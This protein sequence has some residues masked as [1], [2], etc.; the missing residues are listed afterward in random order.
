MATGA[1]AFG[2]STTALVFDAILHKMPLPVARLRPELPLQLGQIIAKAI[3]KSRE[4]RYQTAADLR[5]DLT[6]LKRDTDSSREAAVSDQLPKPPAPARTSRSRMIMAVLALVFLSAAAAVIYRFVIQRPRVR[7]TP[8]KMV[9]TKLTDEARVSRAAL[10]RDG[11]YVAYI[12]R[13]GSQ[14]TLWL[15]QVASQSAVQLLPSLQ[16]VYDW[17]GFSPDGESIYFETER[18]DDLYLYVIPALGG[19][20]RLIT[21]R[22]MPWGV[23]IAPDGKRIAY[24]YHPNGPD[25]SLDIAASDGSGERVIAKGE[26]P[27]TSV[28][29]APS[30]SPDGNLIGA[31]S[32]WFKEGYFTAIRAF[33]F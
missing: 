33:P 9:I 11:R 29:A 16:Q 25:S 23:G 4:M 13:R 31:T 3:E 27:T 15:R 5:A 6:R 2:A 10:S 7:L 17:V 19:S 18:G 30:W 22:A 21:D 14:P 26:V 24:I 8:E 20:P 1:H 28:S 12:S 32:W